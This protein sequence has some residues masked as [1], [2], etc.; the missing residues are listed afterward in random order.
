MKYSLSSLFVKGLISS[1]VIV[2]NTNATFADTYLIRNYP[3]S[4]L[5]WSD[6]AIWSTGSYSDPTAAVYIPGYYDELLGIDTRD[7]RIIFPGGGTDKNLV[8]EV[9]DNYTVA[10]FGPENGQYGVTMNMAGQLNEGANDSSI[11]IKASDPAATTYDFIEVRSSVSYEEGNHELSYTAFNG[12]TVKLTGLNE[13]GTAQI[14]VSCNQVIDTQFCPNH[15]TFSETTT[16]ISESN[17]NIIGDTKASMPPMNL[18]STVNLNGTTIIGANT[19]TDEEPVWSYKTLTIG[20]GS[21]PVQGT[22]LVANITGTLIAN[23]LIQNEK[24]I[25][26]LSGTMDLVMPLTGTWNNSATDNESA[27]RILGNFVMQDGGVLNITGSSSSYS[28]GAIYV[29]GGGSFVMESGSKV[30]LENAALRS[31]AYGSS[32]AATIDIQNGAE[33]TA[34]FLWIGGNTQMTIS[35]KLTTTQSNMYLYGKQTLT[36][37]KNGADL[38]TSS[39]TLAYSSMLIEEDVAEG[40]IKTSYIAIDNDDARLILYSSNPV[41]NAT[42]LKSD[43]VYFMGVIGKCYLDIYADQTFDSLRFFTQDKREGITS[44]DYYVY[45]DNAVNLVSLNTLAN[46]TLIKPDDADLLERYLILDNFRNELIHVDEIDSSID[47]SLISSKN[48]DWTDFRFEA[49]PDG[50]YWLAATYIPEPS[51]YAAILGL[52]SLAL[53]LR[54]RR[55]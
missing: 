27:L 15:L 25:T 10:M 55:K 45:I 37:I 35:G 30:T 42:S 46:N 1:F 38:N 7:A 28:N 48:G 40:S 26:N 22:S 12:G 6:T 33:L 39:I 17:L 5:K 20:T 21:N 9:D 4:P 18:T 11:T 51:V 8:L 43:D 16:F 2:L 31:T 41:V 49:D 23:N 3:G 19:G 36:T 14:K 47:L 13:G 52:T 50:G 24:T 53:V 44:I 54:F 29:G 34:A 32:K